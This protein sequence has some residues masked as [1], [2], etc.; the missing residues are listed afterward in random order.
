MEYKTCT[1]TTTCIITETTP[2]FLRTLN[3]IA[4][5]AAFGS[6]LGILI[7]LHPDKVARIM[8]WTEMGFGFGYTIGTYP[9]LPDLSAVD[10]N[11]LFPDMQ[12]L[13]LEAFST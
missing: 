10:S 7:E 13:L 8:S 1:R 5:A 11:L 12:V 4:D 3:G 9:S 6:V 2:A